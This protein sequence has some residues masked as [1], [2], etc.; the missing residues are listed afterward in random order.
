MKQAILELLRQKRL[1]LIFVGALLLADLILYAVV[2]YYQKPALSAATKGWDDLRGRVA[3]IG[4]GD[5]GTLY[6]QGK[7]DLEKLAVLIPERRQF[8]RVVGDMLDAA[9]SSN[10]AMG[11][12]T[13]LPK[14]VK[15]EN[16][17]AYT[18]QMSVTGRYAAVKSFLS[19]MQKNRELIVIDG[20]TLSN[21]DIFE[22]NV[23]MELRL[24]V[25]LR[26]GA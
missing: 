26:E 12:I 16:L 17:L 4:R 1:F 3:V 2:A 10:V 18:L 24:T 8:P 15:D 6:R 7:G 23:T 22:E 20:I 19:D 25:Y 14:A 5:V 11:A 13:Y 9:A 21:Q